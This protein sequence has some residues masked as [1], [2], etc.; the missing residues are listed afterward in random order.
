M[1]WNN[2]FVVVDNTNIEQ[3][4]SQPHIDHAIAHGAHVA[5]MEFIC[6][7]MLEAESLRLRSSSPP[8]LATVR[9]RWND[10]AR[11]RIRDNLVEIQR[12]SPYSCCRRK[13]GKDF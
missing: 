9:A 5:V 8:P 7:S 12:V 1:E 6:D 11:T 4:E 10:F 2:D 13:E 3:H